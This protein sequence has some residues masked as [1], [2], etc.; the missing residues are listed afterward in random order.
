[1]PGAPILLTPSPYTR[2]A[3]DTEL[4]VGRRVAREV[5]EAAAT[6]RLEE[7]GT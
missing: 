5:R 2:Y 4:S 1:M 3:Y 7:I 6:G